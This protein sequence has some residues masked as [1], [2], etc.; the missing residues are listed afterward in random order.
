MLKKS[1][2]PNTFIVADTETTGVSNDDVII[3]IGAVKVK[4]W[5]IVSMFQTFIR[6]KK[7]ANEIDPFD[8]TGDYVWDGNKRVNL[9]PEDAKRINHITNNMLKD[10]PN[11][12]EGLTLFKDFI[13]DDLVLFHNAG[14]DTRM[15]NAGYKRCFGDTLPNPVGDTLKIA[16]KLYPDLASHKLENLAN[17]FGVVNEAAH[18]ATDDAKTTFLVL[19][20]MLQANEGQG[21]FF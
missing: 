9:I 2:Y 4:D 15:I 17:M 10:A 18:R 13:Q 16:R 7:Y 11:E 3:E 12:L 6:P 19:K 8:S 1:D 5:E 20:R 21:S 14:F